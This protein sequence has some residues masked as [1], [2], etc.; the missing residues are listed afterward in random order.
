MMYPHI[1]LPSDIMRRPRTA[2][3][4]W[5]RDISPTEAR[6]AAK[7]AG[8]SVPHLRHIAAGRRGISADLAQRLVHGANME[9][10]GGLDQQE[11]CDACRKCPLL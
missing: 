1:P 3:R 11:L 5:L 6:A 4:Q 7:V 10:N 2:I 8:T 9:T